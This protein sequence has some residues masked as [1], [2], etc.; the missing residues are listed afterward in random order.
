MGCCILPSNGARFPIPGPATPGT[1]STPPDPVPYIFRVNTATT[2]SGSTADNQINVPFNVGFGGITIDWGDNTTNNYNAPTTSATHTYAA[3]GIY[4]IKI[5][6]IAQNVWFNQPDRLKIFEV[7]QWGISTWPG[8]TNAYR[9]CS[10]LQVVATDAPIFGAMAQLNFAFANTPMNANINHWNMSTVTSMEFMF[11][12][13]TAYNQPVNNWNTNALRFGNGIFVN[14]S[15]FN[16]SLAAWQVPNL[17][18]ANNILTGSAINPDNLASIYAAWSSQT[19]F[20][21]VQFFA[22]GRPYT[23]AIGAAGRAILVGAPNLWDVQDG[24][25]V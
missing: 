7:V 20:P 17:E 9:G 16:Q 23:A 8:L 18:R 1:P 11:S 12:G 14:A 10:N 25:P 21:A 6:N 19:L 5:Y 4:T 13:A 24:G 22:I 2:Y 15:S 3:P